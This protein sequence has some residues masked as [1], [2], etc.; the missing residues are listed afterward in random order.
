MQ[1]ALGAIGS[2]FA[3]GGAGAAATG[4]ATA[5]TAA[6]GFG[7]TALTVL[8]G[9]SAGIAALGQIG[10]ANAA[11]DASEDEALRADL[12]AGQEKVDATNQQ[13][14]MKRELMRILGDNEVA[15]ANAGIDI[16][17]GI[18]PKANAA[19]T[20]DAQTNLTVSRNDQEFRSSLFRIRANQFRKKA[21]S[22]R[23]AGLLSALGTFA[24]FSIDLYQRG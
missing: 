4:A 1:L 5:A 8:Q 24:D 14:Q 9:V 11:A 21:D 12:Q 17:A 2:L 18:A 23:Q 16:S 15:A 6:G 3:G 13:T 20:R 22:Q 10:A 7:S 19:A